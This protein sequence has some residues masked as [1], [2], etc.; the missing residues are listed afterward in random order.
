M[1]N[2]I[3][4]ETLTEP[5]TCRL[6]SLNNIGEALKGEIVSVSTIKGY[7]GY[8]ENDWFTATDYYDGDFDIIP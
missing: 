5:K 6:L 4:Y 7:Y 8:E 2:K 3:H 1:F